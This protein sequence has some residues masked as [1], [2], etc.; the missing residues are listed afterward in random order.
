M[1]EEDRPEM[2]EPIGTPL[3]DAVAF[4]AAA[5]VASLRHPA[6]ANGQ[7]HHELSSETLD[8]LVGLLARKIPESPFEVESQSLALQILQALQVHSQ[9]SQQPPQQ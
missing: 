3:T 9:E 4:V 8:T 6:Q 5:L 7:H 1:N 2:F